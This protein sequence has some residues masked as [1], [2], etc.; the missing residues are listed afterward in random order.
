MKYDKPRLFALRRAP[1]L[2]TVPTLLGNLFIADADGAVWS[3][4]E[5]HSQRTL[6]P[7]ELTESRRAVRAHTTPRGARW[8]AHREFIIGEIGEEKR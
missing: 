8:H 4:Q 3:K 7:A 5:I 6:T 1:H 2:S